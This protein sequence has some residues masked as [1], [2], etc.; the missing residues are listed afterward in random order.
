MLIDTHCHLDAAEFDVDRERVVADAKV[1]GVGMIVV[2]AVDVASFA[3][4]R[5]LAAGRPGIG[6]ALGI[7]PMYVDRAGDDDLATLRREVEAAMADPRFVGIGEIG[8][9][10]F[11]PG[12]D[13]ARQLRF[14]EAQLA[15]AAEFGLPVILHLRRAQDA[16]LKQLRRYRPSGGTAHSFNGSAQQAARFLELGFVLGFGGAMTFDGS[17]RIRRLAASLP[18]DA[19]VVETDAPDIPPVWLDGGRNQ[20]A[21]LGR[22]A[23][24]L[25]GL[26]GEPLQTVAEF[27]TRNALRALP[28]LAGIAPLA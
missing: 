18:A 6:Y 12:L 27:T 20:P 21:E 16:I 25:A 15:L 14:F 19:L 26:R 11:V 8:L 5:S 1:A 17:L 7:H 24:T 4:V 9:D 22:I 10:H 2:P 3:P 13:H 23:Q 28:R